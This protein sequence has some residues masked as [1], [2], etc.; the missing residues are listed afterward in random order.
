VTDQRRRDA[1]TDMSHLRDA[2]ALALRGPDPVEAM[3]V[4]CRSTAEALPVDGAAISTMTGTRHRETLCASDE[5]A[6]ELEE[7]QYSLGEG[8][9]FEAFDLGVPVLLP[10]L[11]TTAGSR[12]PIYASRVVECS[13]ARAV[14]VFPLSFGPL[15]IGTM[16]T[17]RTTP[18]PLETED[19]A[20]G[21]E[22]AQTAALVLLGLQDPVGTAAQLQREASAGALGVRVMGHEQVHMAAGMVAQQLGLSTDAAFDRLRGR[23][24]VESRL[25]VDVASD[26]LAHRVRLD[27]APDGLTD[28]PGPPEQ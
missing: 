15:R 2:V 18:A 28:A 3:R 26:V 19:L 17:Y 13:R 8:P 22:L 20:A 21:S 5:T 16:S 4:V 27:Q 7:L 12:W 6:H 25:L 9:C 10:D 14:F 23:A 1:S 11:D 24:F